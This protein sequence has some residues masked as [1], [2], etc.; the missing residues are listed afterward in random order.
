VT[1]KCNDQYRD[2]NTRTRKMIRTRP[3]TST[4][5]FYGAVIA[6]ASRVQFWES[7]KTGA[8]CYN[9]KN[10]VLPLLLGMGMYQC[11]SFVMRMD[12]HGGRHAELLP[13]M[14]ICKS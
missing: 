14:D 1:L 3:A 12:I 4:D 10:S 13:A 5:T 11:F 8:N 6:S 2:E 7:T 9:N